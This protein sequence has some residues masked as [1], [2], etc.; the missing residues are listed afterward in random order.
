MIEE[1]VI[2][3]FKI[4]TVSIC[5]MIVG[6]ATDIGP[7]ILYIADY[8]K[9]HFNLFGVLPKAGVKTPKGFWRIYGGH[10]LWSSPEAMPRSYSK[11]DKP[12]ELNVGKKEV[13]ICGNPEAENAIRKKITIKPSPESGIQ[14]THIIENVGQWPIRFGCWAIS[15]MRRNG[16]AIIPLKPSRTD[17]E[18]LLPDRHVSLWPYSSLLDER[19]IYRDG[20]ILVK[21]NPAIK[22]P[23]KIGTMVNPNWVAYWVDGMMFLKQFPI[24]D[25]DYPD[26]GCNVEVYTNS[27]MLELET[28]GTLKTVNPSEHIEH[29]EVWKI[30]EVGDLVSEP[31]TIIKKVES[32][33][34]K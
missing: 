21:Q 17:K 8:R 31:D 7:R 13:T 1:R 6:I 33:L 20:Y 5:D 18:G 15:V 2:D 26:Y 34:N 11:D 9:P 14:V 28:I 23:F 3:G 27:N 25:G 30:F 22:H 4:R 16:F 32:L 12:V 24:E 29:I 10:R 19:L